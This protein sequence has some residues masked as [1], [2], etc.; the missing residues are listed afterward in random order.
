MFN[1]HTALHNLTISLHSKCEGKVVDGGGGKCGR[2]KTGEGETREIESVAVVVCIFSCVSCSF[3]LN[4][5]IL[6]LCAIV[7]Y[8]NNE[9]QGLF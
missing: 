5:K 8:F 4:V 6:L 9:Y 3:T 2:Q 1:L 7:F